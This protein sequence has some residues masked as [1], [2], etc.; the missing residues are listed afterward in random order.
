MMKDLYTYILYI[1][2]PIYIRLL[3]IA[4]IKYNFLQIKLF[5]KYFSE[6]CSTREKTSLKI[7]SPVIKQLYRMHYAA[8]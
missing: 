3:Y 2:F 4:N 1:Q 5:Q 8:K 7:M 6:F